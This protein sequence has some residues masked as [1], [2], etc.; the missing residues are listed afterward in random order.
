MHHLVCIHVLD[1]SA[2][3]GGVYMVFDFMD[4]DLTGLLES[5]EI[6]FSIPQIKLYMKQL[7]SGLK[8]LHG[9]DILH[10]DIK[11]ANLLL[12]NSGELKITDFGLAR[13]VEEGRVHYTPGVVTRWYRPPELLYGASKYNSSVDMWGAGCILGEM[14]IK[15]PLLPGESDLHQLD[16][17][18]QLC[19]TP[20]EESMPGCSS[21]PDFAKVKLPMCKRRV[22]DAFAK[23][24]RLAADLMDKLLQLDPAKRLTASQALEHEF[25]KS[26]PFAALPSDLPAYPSKHEFTCQRGAPDTEASRQLHEAPHPTP[27]LHGRNSFEDSPM[28]PPPPPL[29]GHR[30]MSRADGQRGR[31]PGRDR[32]PERRHRSP[33]RDRRPRSPSR[34]RRPRSPSCDRRDRSRD[35]SDRSRSSKGRD[36]KDTLKGKE[37]IAKGKEKH[38]TERSE[39]KSSSK[40]EKIEKNAHL[41]DKE[42]K[43][44]NKKAPKE[45]ASKED[46]TKPRSPSREASRDK[47]RPRSPSTRPS[48][49]YTPA[50]PSAVV[51]PYSAGRNSQADPALI[52]RYYDD[53]RGHYYDEPR[54]GHHYPP[55]GYYR[56]EPRRHHGRPHYDDP[57]RSHYDEP[58]RAHY[59]EPPRD[60]RAHQSRHKRP[61][62]V[63]S[64]V[65]YHTSSSQ[66]ASQGVDMYDLGSPEPKRR[67]ESKRH[68][69]SRRSSNAGASD[70]PGKIPTYDSS[71]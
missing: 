14:L 37:D 58:P 4:H 53:P 56:E 47:P 23:P 1:N 41:K 18:A 6:R 48:A 33:S 10:R 15:K 3:D 28:P 64:G 27:H 46:S 66:A 70:K 39:E 26:A 45:G 60:H 29:P 11:G 61:L 49:D 2:D 40:G 43:T 55:P 54:R 65:D 34:D 38:D 35:R 22:L 52:A 19:G 63:Y 9:V 71:K 25:F 57:P 30:Y 50:H 21:L 42:E 67:E 62:P 12:N 8:Y 20:S 7:L 31:D 24:D 5:P 32:E 36:H 68:E 17:I 69:S 44:E 51:M 59:D 16:L 13:P